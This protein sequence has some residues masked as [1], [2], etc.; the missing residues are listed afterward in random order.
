MVG[1]CNTETTA[2]LVVLYQGQV[3]LISLAQF[4]RQIK[5]EPRPTL[6][7]C[8]KRFKNRHAVLRRNARAEI[9]NI[10][11][12]ALTIGGNASVQFDAAFAH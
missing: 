10:H 11:I 7:G 3:S 12:G 5:A 8:E 2:G 6:V 9:P 4:S 1:E